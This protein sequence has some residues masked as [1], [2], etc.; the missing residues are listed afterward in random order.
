ML[1]IRL[2]SDLLGNTRFA[3]SPLAE[4]ASSLRILG[5]SHSAH[6]HQPWIREVRATQDGCDLSLLTAISPPGKW[7]TSFLYTPAEGPSTTIE[8]Q[9]NGLC[10]GPADAVFDE[11]RLVWGGRVIP[12]A[13]NS[14]IEAGPVGVRRMADALWIYWHAAISPHWSRICAVLEDDVAFR[15][16]RAISGGLF[17]VLTGLHPQVALSGDILRIDKPQHPDENLVAVELTLTPSVFLYPDLLV[18]ANDSGKLCM[19]YSARGV[20]RVWERL[21]AAPADN[22]DAGLGALLG[23]TRATI[24]C[25]LEVP[26]TTT[27]LAEI[28]AL[29]LG[30]VS[31]HLTVLRENGLV[32]SWRTG[33][34][35]LYR[36]T[37]LA[38]T[39]LQAGEHRGRLGSA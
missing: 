7:A 10:E 3:F 27:Q 36:Q 24:L 32:T 35:V 21:G 17:H 33:R 13:I 1:D 22:L 18:G 6:V 19:T 4:V 5:S 15:A 20:G 31:Q 34:S 23:R 2:S 16:S 14:I 9:L 38:T 12:P 37:G 26:K 8:D 30:N 28:L 29:S 25:E 11:L 39:I